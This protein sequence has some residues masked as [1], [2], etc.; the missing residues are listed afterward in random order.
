MGIDGLDSLIPN[1]GRI[2]VEEWNEIL[3]KMYKKNKLYLG[4]NR[5]I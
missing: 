5:A 1:K 3:D 2:S 4:L